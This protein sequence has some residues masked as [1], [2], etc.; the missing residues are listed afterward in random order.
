[1]KPANLPKALTRKYDASELV[2]LYRCLLDVTCDRQEAK[3][4]L[5]QMSSK[6]AEAHM[7]YAIQDGYYRPR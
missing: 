5:Q 2:A 1:M 6:E 3:L 7:Y 4:A